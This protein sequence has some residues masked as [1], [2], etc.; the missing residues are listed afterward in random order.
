MR[1]ISLTDSARVKDIA[2]RAA[3][4]LNIPLT[5]L[6]SK[7]RKQDVQL[8][9]MAVSNICRQEGIHYLD[10]SDVLERDRTSVYHY[11][12]NHEDLYDTWPKY[13]RLFDTLHG[14]IYD[15]PRQTLN[16]SQMRKMLAKEGIRHNKRGR[17]GIYLKSG[18]SK[19]DFNVRYPEF[20][21]VA[22]TIREVLGEY[23]FDMEI[24]L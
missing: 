17:V 8:C 5:A 21:R 16:K 13:Q 14:H 4:V 22:D 1:K 6:F 23:E 20:C 24:S 12:T 9:R 19:Y 18:T 15:N 7:T 11:E 3:E 10:I 2:N